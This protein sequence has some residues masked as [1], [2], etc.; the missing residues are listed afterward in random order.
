MTKKAEAPTAAL[1]PMPSL[2]PPAIAMREALLRGAYVQVGRDH[3]LTAN[4]LEDVIT[5]G[6]ARA[7]DL[8]DAANRHFKKQ[9]QQ[10]GFSHFARGALAGASISVE[11]IDALTPPERTRRRAKKAK[12]TR[13]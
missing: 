3:G 1:P 13:R 10:K 12:K 11:L 8:A 9:D 6:L 2:S 7:A 4:Q 5:L